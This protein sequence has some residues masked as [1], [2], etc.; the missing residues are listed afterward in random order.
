MPSA[1]LQ[2]NNMQKDPTIILDNH[3]DNI[4]LI[5][6]H[7]PE[8]ESPSME[9]YVFHELVNYTHDIFA[10][11][12]PQTEWTGCTK[13]DIAGILSARGFSLTKDEDGGIIVSNTS[14]LAVELLD[15]RLCD[16]CDIIL[17]NEQGKALSISFN[18]MQNSRNF[19]NTCGI[20][21][22]SAAAVIEK[23]FEARPR[24]IEAWKKTR[25]KYLAGRMQSN[26]MEATAEAIIGSELRSSELAY[27]IH[28]RKSCV[29]IDIQTYKCNWITT[30]VDFQDINEATAKRIVSYIETIRTATK[31]LGLHA[32]FSYRG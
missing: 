14:G 19:Y 25:T 3:I 6:S 16:S 26:I 21:P 11:A 23:T 4:T 10:T 28:V 2:S 31:D 20:S 1:T 13:E 30:D 22:E 15:S 27:R 5:A 32:R 8:E 29:S 18:E 17:L 24:L 9:R 7:I 12:T